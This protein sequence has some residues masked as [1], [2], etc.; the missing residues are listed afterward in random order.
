ML[1]TAVYLYLG[2]KGGVYLDERLG[3]SPIFLVVGL[4]MGIALSLRS[5]VA[6]LLAVLADLDKR[7]GLGTKTK[8]GKARAPNREKSNNPDSEE[9]H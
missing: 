7:K 5:L 6:E 1:A 4:L 3:S 8:E 2:Y 9:T